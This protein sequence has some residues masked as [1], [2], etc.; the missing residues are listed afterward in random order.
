MFIRLIIKFTLFANR[1]KLNNMK[2]LQDIEKL[3]V[4]QDPTKYWFEFHD[5]KP[6]LENCS[7]SAGQ[8]DEAKTE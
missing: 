7:L 6:G 5:K 1:I 8:G 2:T 3:H 4:P